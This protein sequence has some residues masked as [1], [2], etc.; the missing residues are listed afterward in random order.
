MYKS[1]FDKVLKESLPKLVLFYGENSF[2]LDYYRKFYIKKLNAKEELLEHY[3]DEYNFEQAK[4]YLSQGSLFGGENLYILKTDKKL[5]KK[6]L[7]TLIELVNKS[8]NNYFLYIYEGSPSNAKGLQ[9]SF[10]Q[11][12]GAIWVRF[13][14]ANIKEAID[15]ATKRANELNINITPYAINHLVN[16]LNGNLSLID[17][18]LEKLSILDKEIEAGDIDNL[19][20]STAPLAVEKMLISLFKKEDIVNTINRLIEL[21]E[22]E[23]SILR[24]VQRFLQ[25]LLMFHIYIKLYGAPNSK[26]ILG[27]QLPK[28]IEQERASLAIKIKSSTYL[29]IYQELLD[30]EIK[31]KKSNP[32]NK[33][34]LL[35]GGLIKIRDLL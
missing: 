21:G 25:Q 24:S 3:Y 12:N 20:Y 2:Y 8:T 23:F 6:E 17:K 16:L 18:E 7:D 13:F 32:V 19:V 15:F 30:L 5:P 29:K 33:E 9:N 10:S 1:E 34:S 35:Y 4:A 22:D 14:E 31:I 26:E 27:Y 11:K 28:F